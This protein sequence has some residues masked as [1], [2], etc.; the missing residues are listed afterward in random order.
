M[1]NQIQ[2]L[3]S[4]LMNEDCLNTAEPDQFLAM[5]NMLKIKLFSDA[6]EANA[7]NDEN[8]NEIAD[9]DDLN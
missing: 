6:S 5:K 2:N 4:E 7:P 1:N 9:E 8:E 3:F